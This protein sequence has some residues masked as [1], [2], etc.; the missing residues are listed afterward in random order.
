MPSELLVV[1]TANKAETR[2]LAAVPML[3]AMSVTARLNLGINNERNSTGDYSARS[4]TA[5]TYSQTDPDGPRD[6]YTAAA[7]SGR[8]EGDERFRT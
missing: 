4:G 7:H 3:H 5:P 8:E 6:Y 1:E 2:I